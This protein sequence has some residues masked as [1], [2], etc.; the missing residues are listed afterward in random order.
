MLVGLSRR[1]T[2]PSLEVAAASAKD[3]NAWLVGSMSDMAPGDILAH[4][5]L[6]ILSGLAALLVAALVFY[7]L[8]VHLGIVALVFLIAWE[9][10]LTV[11]KQSLRTLV[12]AVVGMVGGWFLVGW[13]FPL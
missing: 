9:I 2:K 12:C 13:L 3:R 8:G 4:A 7:L 5:S 6:D 10:V 11:G 1:N